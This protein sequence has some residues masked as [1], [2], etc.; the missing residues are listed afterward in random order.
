MPPNGLRISRRERAAQDDIKKGTILR[1]KRSGCMRGL[2]RRLEIR[3]PF[4]YEIMILLDTLVVA[5]EV[6]ACMVD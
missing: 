2:A 6:P 1:A 4:V 3:L 5:H